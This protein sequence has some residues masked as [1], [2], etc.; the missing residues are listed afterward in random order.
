MN[1]KYIPTMTAK[2]K[3]QRWL[4][5]AYCVRLLDKSLIALGHRFIVWPGPIHGRGCERPACGIG[6]TAREA[7]ASVKRR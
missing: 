7:W 6:R 5:D 1:E 3:V 4:P 2:Q